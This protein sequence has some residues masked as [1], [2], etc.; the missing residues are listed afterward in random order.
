MGLFEK[1]REGP[2]AEDGSGGLVEF[3]GGAME[4]A[5]GGIGTG[6]SAVIADDR[7]LAGFHDMEQ[8]DL[9]WRYDQPDATFHALLG[10]QD[11]ASDQVADDFGEVGG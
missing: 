4:G 10:L 5:D 6:G 1:L 2:T 7:T 8:G 11:A 9:R 3:H